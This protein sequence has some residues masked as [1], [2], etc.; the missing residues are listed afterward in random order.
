ML[1]LVYGPAIGVLKE[2]APEWNSCMLEKK[3]D[4]Y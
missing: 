1:F 4:T 3:Q 2:H